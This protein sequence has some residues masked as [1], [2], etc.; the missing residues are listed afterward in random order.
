VSGH[1]SNLLAGVG[2]LL[3]DASVGVWNPTGAYAS[4]QTGIVVKVIPQTP[5]TIIAISTYPVTDEPALS[6]SVVGLQVLTRAGG[7][8]PSTVDDLADAVFD[9]LHGLHDHTLSTG[10]RVVQCLHRSGGSLGQDD[11][12]RWSRSDNYYVTTHRPSPNRT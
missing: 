12:H 8:D 11:L 3:A 9:Q 4:G 10:V 7:Q 1:Q 6:D 5:D 2:A